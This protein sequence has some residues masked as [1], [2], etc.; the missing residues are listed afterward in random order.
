[1]DRYWKSGSDSLS[2]LKKNNMKTEMPTIYTEPVRASAVVSPL[3]T[4]AVLIREEI[5][6]PR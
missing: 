2:L 5:H 4:A 6:G 3:D 1:M